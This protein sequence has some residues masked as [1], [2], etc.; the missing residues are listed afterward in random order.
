VPLEAA[1]AALLYP[2]AELPIERARQWAADARRQIE[3]HNWGAAARPLGAAEAAA[4]Y[5]GDALQSAL[6]QGQYALEQAARAYTVGDGGHGIISLDKAQVFLQR[7]AQDPDG[8]SADAARDLQRGLADTMA[9][10]PQS[11]RVDPAAVQRL[12]DRAR[13]LGERSAEY[14]MA[15]WGWAPGRDPVLSDLVEAKTDLQRARSDRAHGGSRDEARTDL[16]DALFRLRRLRDGN[17]GTVPPD[18][19]ALAD[20]VAALIPLLGRTTGPAAGE[21]KRYDSLI[22]QLRGAIATL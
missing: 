21:L 20:G 11:G 15:G 17:W 16:E 12:S 8:S 1:R 6:T 19:A 10:L 9:P 4:R 5:V 22:T 7:A 18:T 14:R 13:A 2:V 3:A